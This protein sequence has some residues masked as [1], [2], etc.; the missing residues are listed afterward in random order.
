MASGESFVLKICFGQTPISSLQKLARQIF[1]QFPCPILEVEF[2]FNAHWII[3]QIK[4]GA[5]NKLTETEQDFFGFDHSDV[6]YELASQWSLPTSIQE[7]ILA[8]HTPNKLEDIPD[9]VYVVHIANSLA[10]LCELDSDDFS[11]AAPILDTAWQTLG[12]DPSQATEIIGDIKA[13]AEDILQ[14]FSA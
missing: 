8:H 3:S 10:V 12:L 7:S 5:I 11:E 9:L 14:A 6:G 2:S 4:A 1:E 13:S